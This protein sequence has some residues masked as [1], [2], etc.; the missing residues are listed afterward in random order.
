V[1]FCFIWSK[2]VIAVMCYASMVE[3]QPQNDVKA[4]Q[5]IK[6]RQKGP[7]KIK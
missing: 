2:T 6:Y 4:S 1:W 7:D 5:T 3:K